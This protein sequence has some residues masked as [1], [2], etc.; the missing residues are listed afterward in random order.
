MSCL[1][2][3]AD[4]LQ[5][6]RLIESYRSETTSKREEITSLATKPV[7]F[8]ARRCSACGA[9]LDL[10][11]VHFLC[12]HSFHQKCINQGDDTVECPVCT[13]H[14]ATIRAIK[15]RQEESAEQH[16]LFRSILTSSRERFATISDFFGK[17]VMG[18]ATNE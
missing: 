15:K 17:G 6:R 10:P 16:T 1:L 14:N 5:N 2:K 18:V 9:N 7:V 12:K 3:H 8:Q 11:T 13:P 4:S